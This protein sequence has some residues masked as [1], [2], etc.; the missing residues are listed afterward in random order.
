MNSW[1]TYYKE[2]LMINL[3]SAWQQCLSSHLPDT[4]DRF[5]TTIDN[6]YA[7]SDIVPTM[8]DV[9]TAYELTAPNQVRVV[10]LGQDPYPNESDAMGLAFSIPNNTPLPKS[11]INIFKELQDDLGGTL[12]TSG[13][14]TDWAQQGV[15]LLNTALTNEAGERDAH[16]KLGWD[17]NLIIPTIEYLVS[18]NQPIV[19]IL[20][21]KSAEKYQKYLVNTNQ[22]TI[23]SPHPSPLGAYRGFWKSKPFSKSNAYLVQNNEQP[24][25][26]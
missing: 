24:I 26:W 18:T 17:K 1:P 5:I 3:P 21:G 4:H 12:R 15:L 14:L 23:I 13:D 2:K 8:S 9:Y 19:Y 25:I 22:M 20:W 7:T 11:L 10:I 16:K 6:L